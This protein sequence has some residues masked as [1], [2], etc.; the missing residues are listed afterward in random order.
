MKITKQQKHLA[1]EAMYAVGSCVIVVGVF[2][3]VLM[4]W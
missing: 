4:S 2:L 1:S 3:L